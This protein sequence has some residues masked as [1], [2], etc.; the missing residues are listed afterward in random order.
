[1]PLQVVGMAAIQAVTDLSQLQQDFHTV[2][3]PGLSQKSAAERGILQL[4]CLCMN[5]I[6]VHRAR[7]VLLDILR[8]CKASMMLF[9]LQPEQQPPEALKVFRQASLQKAKLP[10]ITPMRTALLCLMSTFVAPKVSSSVHL[11]TQGLRYG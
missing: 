11:L 1:M 5:P 8:R 3:L 9:F 4:T 2:G 10:S 6:F 7:Q